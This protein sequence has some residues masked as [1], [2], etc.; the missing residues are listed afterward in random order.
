LYDAL[1]NAVTQEVTAGSIAALPDACFGVGLLT[2]VAD[3]A[4]TVSF[5]LK[6]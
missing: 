1:G 3:A 2:P 5:S 4:G 6:G